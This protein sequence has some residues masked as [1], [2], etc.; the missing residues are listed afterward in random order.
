MTKE[1][2]CATGE[3]MPLRALR[4]HVSDVQDKT[5]HLSG[6]IQAIAYLEG[7]N[8]CQAGQ[9]ALIYIAEDMIKEIDNALDALN[10]PEVAA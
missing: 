4:S 7:E 2:I 3:A 6:V 1:R 8:A 5:C 9:A 10:L